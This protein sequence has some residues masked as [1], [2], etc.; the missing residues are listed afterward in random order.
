MLN[1][2]FGKVYGKN[3]YSVIRSCFKGRGVKSMERERE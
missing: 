1:E 3:I 2:I